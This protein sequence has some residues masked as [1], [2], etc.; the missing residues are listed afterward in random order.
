MVERYTVEIIE[1]GRPGRVRY[2]EGPL[3][4]RDFYWDIAPGLVLIYA[5]TAGE[6]PGLLPWAAERRAEVLDR[7]ATEVCRKRCRD[8]RPQVVDGWLD[9]LEPE[10]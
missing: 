7:V 6:W 1:E 5:P 3:E 4:S 8:C 10:I 2:S 9:L